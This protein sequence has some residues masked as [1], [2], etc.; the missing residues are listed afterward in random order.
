MSDKYLLKCGPWEAEC[1]PRWG[2]NTVALR[3]EGRDILRCPENEDMLHETDISPL[4]YGQPLLLPANR[5]R[6]GKFTFEGT[7]YQLPL[8]ETE[9][10][11]N[12]HGQLF[13]TPFDVPEHTETKIVGLLKNGGLFYPFPFR[14]TITDELTEEGYTRTVVLENTGKTSMPY[15]VGFHTAFVEPKKLTVPLKSRNTWDEKW[16]PT[17]Q[18][19]PDIFDNSPIVGNVS[20]YYVSGGNR[21]MLDDIVYTVSENFDHWILYNGGGGK[22]FVCVEPQ[23]GAV[24]GLN[25]PGQ[26]RVLQP[27]EKETFT[28]SITKEK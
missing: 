12:Q 17:G 18:T 10:M 8:N 5:T 23:C 26:H 1:L 7:E 21:A 20:G 16:F 2:M 3:Y 6:D 14:I 25:H 24:N 22:G 4:L 11:C 15:T 27:G 13:M 19:D 28:L 9:T